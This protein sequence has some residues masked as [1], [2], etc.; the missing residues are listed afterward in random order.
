MAERQA[1]KME[2]LEKTK[3]E[4]KIEKESKQLSASYMES[5]KN[6]LNSVN[7]NGNIPSSSLVLN[8]EFLR[9]FFFLKFNKA[10]ILVFV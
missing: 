1:S 10:R 4:L 8:G 5:I 3:C 2:E 7:T 9:I 6:N